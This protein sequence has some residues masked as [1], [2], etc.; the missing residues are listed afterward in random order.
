MTSSEREQRREGRKF[1]GNRLAS[2]HS[3]LF[4]FQVVADTVSMRSDT[5][6]LVVGLKGQ[7]GLRQVDAAGHAGRMP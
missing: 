5:S 7:M 2:K 3:D 1:D 4:G 6:C